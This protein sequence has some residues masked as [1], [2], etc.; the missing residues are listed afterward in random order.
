MSRRISAFS[1]IFFFLNPPDRPNRTASQ[2]R[3][4]P[5][6]FRPRRRYRNPGWSRRRGTPFVISEP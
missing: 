4:E 5:D 6:D 2:T 1:G 3:V